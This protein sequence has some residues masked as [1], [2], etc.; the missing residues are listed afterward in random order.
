P[1][2]ARRLPDPA[3]CP[4]RAARVPFLSVQRG[5]ASRRAAAWRFGDAYT[6][7]ASELWTGHGRTLSCG[8]IA[9]QVRRAC[10]DQGLSRSDYGRHVRRALSTA[11]RTAGQPQLCLRRAHQRAGTDEPRA[12]ADA[13]DGG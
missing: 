2:P 9:S 11:F 6:L 13:L 12:E 5:N 1:A 3:G 4:F 7:A 10:F 8:N